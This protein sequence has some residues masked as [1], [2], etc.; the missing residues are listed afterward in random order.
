VRADLDV[1]D[2]PMIFEQLAA[3]R[4]GDPE[5]NEQ[6]RRRYLALHLQA[7]RPQPAAAPLPGTPPTDREHGR[8]WDRG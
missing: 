1:N 5:R 3:I 2:V 8:R 4:L 7:I 6:L